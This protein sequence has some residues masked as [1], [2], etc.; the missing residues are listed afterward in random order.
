MSGQ[1]IDIDSWIAWLEALRQVSVV[2][3]PIVVALVM[4]YV[5]AGIVLRWR[6]RR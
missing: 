1:L 2:V 4:A 5:I 6:W 3:V